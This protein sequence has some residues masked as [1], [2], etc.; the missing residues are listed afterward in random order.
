MTI[1]NMTITKESG[2]IAYTYDD[3]KTCSISFY[4]SLDAEKARVIK[5]PKYWRENGKQ[6]KVTHLS[7][8]TTTDY[9]KEVHVPKDVSVN[10]ALGLEVVYYE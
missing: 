10:G 7:L 3:D 2:A 9:N 4:P 1:T 6:Y 8:S 5:C